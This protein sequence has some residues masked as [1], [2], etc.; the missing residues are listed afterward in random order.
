ML[1]ESGFSY[2]GHTCQREARDLAHCSVVGVFSYLTPADVLV[3]QRRVF[4]RDGLSVPA[5]RR[6]QHL[7]PRGLRF[8]SVAGVPEVVQ[9]WW[10]GN[11][12]QAVWQHLK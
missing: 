6:G 11:P 3:R 5:A 2:W 1:P 4:P 7:N 10:G 8:S 9:R 12:Y